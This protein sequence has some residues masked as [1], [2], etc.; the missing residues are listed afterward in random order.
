MDIPVY[1]IFDDTSVAKPSVVQPEKLDP[2]DNATPYAQY[3]PFRLNAFAAPCLRMRCSSTLLYR[4]LG[5]QYASLPCPP[6]RS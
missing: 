3:I 6:A 5:S 4:E 1:H 2:I